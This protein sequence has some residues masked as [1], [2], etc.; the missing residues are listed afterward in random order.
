VIAQ[1]H[2]LKKGSCPRSFYPTQVDTGT[3]ACTEYAVCHVVHAV[4]KD[5]PVQGNNKF[6]EAEHIQALA[7]NQDLQ[8]RTA[9]PDLP[10]GTLHMPHSVVIKPSEC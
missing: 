8:V 5:L 9:P 7:A 2:F 3:K 10:G 1:K 6:L 4:N